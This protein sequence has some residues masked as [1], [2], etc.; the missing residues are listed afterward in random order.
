MGTFERFLQNGKYGYKNAESAVVIEPQFDDGIS[1]F[2][3]NSY[4]HTEYA[5]VSKNGK[6]GMIHESG[7]IIVPFEYQE[8][9]HLFDEYFAVRKEMPEGGWS[10]GVIKPD[11]TIV[12][13]FEYKRITK[14]GNSFECYKD[15]HSSRVYTHTLF[16]TN[17]NVF[18]Y[19]WEKDP[20]VYN[21]NGEMIYEGSVIDSKNGYLI[22]SGEDKRGVIDQDGK[23]VIDIEYE[24]IIIV[25]SDRIIARRN[26]G[27]SWQFGVLDSKSN[28]IID[29]TY[30][31][32]ISNEGAFFNC[33]NEC[34]SALKD[35]HSH[36]ERYE[37]FNK[38]QEFWLNS[39]GKEVYRGK[40]EVLSEEL[41]ACDKDG[42][43]AVIN[44]NGKKIVN[45][46]YDRIQLLDNF[47]I[48]E[49]DSKVGVL[50][51]SGN[52]VIDA[53]YSNIEFVHID[54]SVTPKYTEYGHQDGEEYGS[55]SKKNPFDTAAEKDRLN[56]Q[57]IQ[58]VKSRGFLPYT[59]ISCPREHYSFKDIMILRTDSYAELFSIEDGIIH[60]SRFDT[61][62]QL[63]NLSYVVS[64]EGKYGVY[65]RDINRLIIECDF[66]RII[67]EGGHVV[68]LLKMDYGVQKLWF[69]LNTLY[70]H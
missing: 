17:G 18:K 38:K 47:L 68:L 61:V 13:P 7:K 62:K 9:C 59:G 57:L 40:A 54:D 12:V 22:V 67:F 52:V 37:Y 5:P 2:G 42:K 63:T 14:V 41:L 16:D 66:E 44:S 26:D 48:V 23:R 1:T 50:T 35:S 70:I 15:A 55:Y 24:D 21:S 51:D 28:I 31:Y 60:N 25:N 43:K 46:L 11:G 56:R 4:N 36:G 32:I 69:F 29:F 53:L 34:D 19:S 3:L 64:K 65:R 6:C 33:F 45:F 49:K 10:C 30:K 20:V 39:I 58:F 8:V 27:D